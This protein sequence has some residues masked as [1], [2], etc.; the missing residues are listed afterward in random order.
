MKKKM[1]IISAFAGMI[2]LGLC[3]KFTAGSRDIPI[4]DNAV[5]IEGIV[6]TEGIWPEELPS[7]QELEEQKPKAQDKAPVPEKVLPE[8]PVA[9]LNGEEG[10]LRYDWEKNIIKV[11]EDTLLL[12]GDHYFSEERL[13]QRIV[14]LAKAPDFVPQEVF[15]QDSRVYAEEPGRPELLE[16]RMPCP[17]LVEEGCVF[18][19]DGMLYFLN[20]E[21]QETVPLCDLRELMGESY[22]F[23]PWLV[24]KNKCDVTADV[25]KLLVCTDEGL[26]EYNLG[27]NGRKLLE[28][29][30]FTPYEIVH[31]EGDC[32]CGET[33]FEFE[34]PVE[35]EYVPGGQGYVFLT[36]TEYGNPTGGTL[37]SAEGET[38]YQREI[39]EYV[40]GFRW[41]EAGDAV[42]LA[43]FYREDGRAW[44]E[45]V[46]VYTGEK[47][48]FAVPDEVL[49][50][51]DLYVG[52]LHADRL[53]YYSEQVSESWD[54]WESDDTWKSDY[55]VYRLSDEEVEEPEDTGDI[56]GKL[57]VL[58]LGGYR[59]TIVRY[60]D[61]SSRIYE[62]FLYVE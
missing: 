45:R 27:N 3:V 53:I 50:G 13:Q 24:D 22:L 43:V 6:S 2:V 8:K 28:P 19:A 25:S 41:I 42:Y 23:S 54:I 18:E 32:D 31:V 62:S 26:Y 39:K 44:M 55:K 49:F 51:G 29:A 11:D 40:G 56:N 61:F 37:R 52:F 16:R 5:V 34:G 60:S 36:G 10:E 38:L 57:I 17:K 33:G 20:D 47:E 9:E 59:K 35:A 4:V 30:V 15:R 21:F 12:V 48:V 58:D 46:D 14:Y 7:E 1:L